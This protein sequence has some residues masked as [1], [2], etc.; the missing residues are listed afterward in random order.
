MPYSRKECTRGVR[1][2]HSTRETGEQSGNAAEQVEGWAIAN[3]FSTAD[4]AGV[5]YL[6]FAISH[7]GIVQLGVPAEDVLQTRPASAVPLLMQ[8]RRSAGDLLMVALLSG[9][10]IIC[11][12]IRARGVRGSGASGHGEH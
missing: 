9:L 6:G 7:G 8:W 3:S 11:A 1:Q 2:Q 5:K 10:L 12:F 4:L